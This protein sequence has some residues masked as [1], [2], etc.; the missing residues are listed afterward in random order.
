MRIERV[1]LEHHGDAA[2]RR[3]DIVHVAAGQPELALGDRVEAGDQPQQ[4]RF[5]A[6]RGADEDDE[7][8]VLDLEID[9]VEH[10]DGLEPL[11]DAAQGKLNQDMFS[12]WW[13]S[14]Q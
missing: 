6:A 2:P 11:L 1:G 13:A 9:A 12:G 14:M 7:F 10:I 4:R 5:S 3:G 8:L